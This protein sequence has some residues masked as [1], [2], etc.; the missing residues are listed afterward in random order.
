MLK[1]S[2]NKNE[3]LGDEIQKNLKTTE[4]VHKYIL[5]NKESIFLTN[6]FCCN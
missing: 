1:R 3:T 5:F 6:Y 2:P 4:V